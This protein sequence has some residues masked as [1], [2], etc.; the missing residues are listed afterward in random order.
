MA[1][2]Q[3]SVLSY[4][5]EIVSHGFPRAH[6]EID[7]KWSVAY[8][9]LEFDPMKFPDPAGM[10]QELHHLGFKVT[11][12]LT[13]FAALDSDA[14]DEG[15]VAGHWIR[16]ARSGTPVTVTWWQGRGAL[17]N[18][19]DGDACE[20]MERRLRKLASEVGIDGFKFD[21]GEGVFV[22]PG[23]GIDTNAYAA[24]WARFAARFGGGGEVRCAAS[25]QDAGLW[26][27]A[28][29]KDS[30]WGHANGL[31][32]M[33]ITALQHGVLGYPFV[34]PDM[35]GGNAYSEEMMADD[36][37][38]GGEGA[39]DCRTS[40]RSPSC[41]SGNVSIDRASHD[42]ASSGELEARLSV[43]SDL[44][45]GSIPD[46]E[47]YIRWCFASALLPAVQFSIAPWQYD[48][49]TVEACR[50]ALS[51]RA[52]FLPEIERLAARA[53]DIGE[54]IVRPLWWHAP[55]DR[56]SFEVDDEF[57]LGDNILVA[58]VLE[59]D[60]RS[61]AI[62]LPSGQWVGREGFMHT[63][64]CWLEKYPVELDE[65]AIFKLVSIS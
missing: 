14:F 64:P 21:A 49:E 36:D 35:V 51:L 11:L 58:P 62:Y 17:L 52:R 47:L 38:G 59:P 18:L 34:L 31:R 6:L 2:D 46:R 5:E 60:A 9:D 45:H 23:C 28:F 12:W 63:G 33:I 56:V 44:F 42:D 39:H 55:K 32:S 29:D 27:R 22:P 7:D 40:K 19:D 13:P 26:L 15:A 54:P 53:I 1:V 25:S 20:W 65:L 10:V 30:S 3:A 43:A 61:R 8:G 16:E 50:K 37:G 57:M 41:G 48:A 4:A 24:A